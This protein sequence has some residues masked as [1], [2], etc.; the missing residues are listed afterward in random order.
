MPN[1]E[2]TSASGLPFATVMRGYDRDQVNDFF[3]RFDAEMRVI[4][5]DRDAAT[6]N[7][8]ELAE[9][10]QFAREEIEELRRE[11][12]KLSVP[13]TTVQGMSERVSSMLRLASDEASEIRARSEAEAAETLSIAR[14]EAEEHRQE[15]ARQTQEMNERREAMNAEHEATMS[16]AHDEAARIVAEAK[17]QAEELDARAQSNR[18]RIQEDFDLTMAA[19]R[20]EA[21]EQAQHLEATSKAEAKERLDAAHAEAESTRQRA[22]SAATE[23]VTRAQ[24]VTEQ[25]RTL[26]ARMLAQLAEIR[27]QLDDVPQLLAEV[28]NEP[29]L[30]APDT[31]GLLNKELSDNARLEQ[32][33]PT[34]TPQDSDISDD[35]STPSDE[36][37][38]TDS[39]PGAVSASY[40]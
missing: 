9:N 8:R 16:A 17:A 21:L 35:D 1:H 25:I 2:A 39:S 27:S 7:A 18:E 38:E 14:Q 19:R 22:A 33:N 11:V 29:E 26:R 13:P 36:D 37:T 31:K 24:E 15:I 34:A 20:K 32:P 30:L 40:R 5:A 6:A 28:H 12:N 10:L 23:R 3:R 4:A